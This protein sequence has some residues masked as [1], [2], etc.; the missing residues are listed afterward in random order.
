MV[1]LNEFIVC[2]FTHWHVGALPKQFCR[3]AGMGWI[4]VL[5]DNKSHSAVSRH[6]A[7]EASNGIESTRGSANAGHTRRR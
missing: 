3:Q 4:E 7:K 6:R 2:R 1:G 5:N